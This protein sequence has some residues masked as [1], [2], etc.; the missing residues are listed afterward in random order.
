[1]RNVGGAAVFW[2]HPDSSLDG[3]IHAFLA[4]GRELLAKIG[5]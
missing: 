2:D 4:A 3:E 5:P 1:M